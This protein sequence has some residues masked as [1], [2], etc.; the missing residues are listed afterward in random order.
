VTMLHKKH[1]FSW[2]NIR[3]DKEDFNEQEL[4]YGFE[5]V[6]QIALDDEDNHEASDVFT[7][8]GEEESYRP[9]KVCF[10]SFGTP[11]SLTMSLVLSLSCRKNPEHKKVHPFRKSVLLQKKRAIQ[12]IQSLTVTHSS[13]RYRSLP[14]SKRY[15]SVKTVRCLITFFFFFYV[16]NKRIS[17]KKKQKTNCLYQIALI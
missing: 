7:S 14:S 3:M 16:Q 15:F 10:Y 5:L 2:L 8:D 17:K 12:I 4:T 11:S 6:L 13:K 1:L 9:P